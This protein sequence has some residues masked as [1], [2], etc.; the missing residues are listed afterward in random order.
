M[1]TVK[2]FTSVFLL[3]LNCPNFSA[4]CNEHSQHSW[5][6]LTDGGFYGEYWDQLNKKKQAQI[7]AQVAKVLG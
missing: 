7:C 3:L 2:G 1:T 4:A 5:L 6:E